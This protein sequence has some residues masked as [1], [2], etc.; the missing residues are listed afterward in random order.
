MF[1]DRAM[2]IMPLLKQSAL[3]KK[4][5]GPVPVVRES[6]ELSLGGERCIICD[7]KES[8]IVVIYVH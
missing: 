3:M 7:T 8:C 6:L 5:F 4:P 1:P 2:S